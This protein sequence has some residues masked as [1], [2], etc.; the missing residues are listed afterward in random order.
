M[1]LYEIILPTCDNAGNSLDS[2]HREFQARVLSIVNGLTKRPE[3]TGYWKTNGTIQTETVVAYQV[4]CLPGQWERIVDLAVSL[5]PDQKAFFTAEIGDAMIV[6]PD[7][8]HAE[9]TVAVA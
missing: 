3:A 9:E 2:E 6:F 8:F 1:K 4:A 7:G 5:F